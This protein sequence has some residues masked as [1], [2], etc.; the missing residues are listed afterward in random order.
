MSKTLSDKQ[1]FRV[2]VRPRRMG[3]Y[4]CIKISESAC[5]GFDADSIRHWER[6]MRRRCEEIVDDI[7]RHADG[8]G[9]VDIDFDQYD[10]CEH[11][12]EAW[13]ADSGECNGCCDK[14]ISEWEQRTG[15]VAE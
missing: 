3:D 4:G 11:C 14:E 5:R 6:S 7:K 12:K 8:V 9:S 13:T 1:D 15:K 10:I 2:V